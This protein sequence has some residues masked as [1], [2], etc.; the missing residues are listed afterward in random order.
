MVGD[1]DKP[2][3]ARIKK[4]IFPRNLT[5]RA[6]TT[7][8][9][10]PANARPESGVDNTHPGLE[11][12][13]RN[14]D[15]TFFPGLVFEFQYLLGARL[16]EVHPGLFTYECDVRPTDVDGDIYLWYVFGAFGAQP[17]QP[18]L[19]DLFGTD[20]YEVLRMVHDLEPGPLVVIIGRLPDP[21][22]RAQ[23]EE[24][25]R[26]GISFADLI[27]K[28]VAGERPTAAPPLRDPAGKLLAA[29]L[30]GHRA[31]YLDANGVIMPSAV[32]PGGL[33]R[34]LCAPW[35]WD[36]ADCGCHYWA[37]NKP[38]IVIG[39]EGGPQTLN[40]QRDRD[41]LGQPG[42]PRKYE[43]WIAG[44]MTQPQMLLR[45]ETLPFVLA[46]QEATAWRRP[47]PGKVD[48]LWSRERIIQELTYLAGVEHALCVE[49]L[50][51]HYSLDAPEKM[52]KNGLEG[53][54]LD[55]FR[56]ATE[57]FTIAVDEMRH[58][59]WVNE[60][61]QLLGAPRCLNRAT[62]HGLLDERKD[63]KFGLTPLTPERL[64]L[65]IDVEAPSQNI[66]SDLDGLYTH[67]LVSLQRQPDDYGDIWQRLVEVIKLIIDEGQGHFERLTRIQE[68]LAP[69]DCTKYLRLLGGPTPEKKAENKQLQELADSYYHTLL[70]GLEKAFSEKEHLR[71]EL[72]KQARRS[73][74]NLHEVGH[75]LADRGVGL[76]FSMPKPDGSPPHA[77]VHKSRARSHGILAM[78]ASAADQKVK[79]LVSQHSV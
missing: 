32:P 52:P 39:P 47:D 77:K 14:L 20:G 9:G 74:Y 12:D 1:A 4:K 69:Y 78:L 43:S 65:F 58:L 31:E 22:D 63:W 26:A 7:V 41:T 54:T 53:Q 61:L 38:D 40:F 66:T 10:N 57:M 37:A 45:W 24:W 49:Y 71:G 3:D 42:D 68:L 16:A 8:R 72:L 70:S 28:A 18:R 17:Q 75:L 76:L 11:F 33:T 55:V 46:E 56:A 6:D 44:E 73:M 35:Q 23:I 50:Y 21:E 34:S 48:N 79:R 36:F 2:I 19:V 15:K 62:E 29:V 30:V 27:S 60:A 51:A 59:R 5:A 13:Q 64:Q 25:L 67:I